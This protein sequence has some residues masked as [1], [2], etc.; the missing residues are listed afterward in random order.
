MDHPSRLDLDMLFGGEGGESVLLLVGESVGTGVQGLNA[1]FE[2]PST[3]SSSR[4]GPVPARMGVRS[5]IT[6][7]Y[8]SPRRVCLQTC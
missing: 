6:V 7:T 8:L 3:M 1:S 4:A 2:R 5:M